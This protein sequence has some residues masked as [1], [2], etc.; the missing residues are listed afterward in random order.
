MALIFAFIPLNNRAP[1]IQ[2]NA[3]VAKSGG[4]FKAG[5][6]NAQDL[7]TSS[8]MVLWHNKLSYPVL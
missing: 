1:A 4:L 5:Q 7:R 8:M 2:T 3:G 6:S